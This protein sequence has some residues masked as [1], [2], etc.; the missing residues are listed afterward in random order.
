MRVKANNFF[1]PFPLF[2][3]LKRSTEG[4]YHLN[5]NLKLIGHDYI[6]VFKNEKNMLLSLELFP[7]LF[8][9]SVYILGFHRYIIEFALYLAA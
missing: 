8:V 6:F 5:E 1:L 4:S 2:W 9:I 3:K 7:Y